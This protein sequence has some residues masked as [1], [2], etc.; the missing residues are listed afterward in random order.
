MT[1]SMTGFAS[2]AVKGNKFNGRLSMRT[3]NH[4]YFDWVYNGPEW[5]NLELE[6]R[7]LAQRWINRGR[8]E[9][10]LDLSTV[11]PHDWEV[12][13]EEGLLRR[14]GGKI[15]RLEAKIG[16]PFPLT[17]EILFRLP[18]LISIRRRQPTT[19][20]KQLIIDIFIRT[21][22]KVVREREREGRKLGMEIRRS[23]FRMK[24]SLAQIKRS[25]EKQTLSWRQ[26][27][28]ARVSEILRSTPLDQKRL[29]E[30]VAYLLLRSDIKEE[31]V[32]I[33]TYLDSLEEIITSKSAES[34]GRQTDFLAQELWR[35][36]STLT[37]KS[38]D[39][40]VVQEGLKM[41]VEVEII[42]Q[43]CQNIE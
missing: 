18:Q 20:E 26:Q 35:E 23:I 25:Q 3:Y 8:V 41:K 42:R 36:I 6:L 17:T 43:Q 38:S 12:E 37:S 16:Q 32:R 31:I 1:R 7:S 33:E 24:K 15:R 21:L 28:P 22:E 27:L 2:T 13:V 19:E 34:K 14:L 39:L 5:G 10:Y 40:R 11:D 30:E 9:V 29:E 4:R